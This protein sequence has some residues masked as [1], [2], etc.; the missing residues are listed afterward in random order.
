MVISVQVGFTTPGTITVPIE[1]S[2][3]APG[4]ANVKATLNPSVLVQD[5]A[6]V[7]GLV[8]QE[9]SA[10]KPSTPAENSALSTANNAVGNAKAFANQGDYANSLAQWIN[11]ADQVRTITSVDTSRAKQSIAYA[12]QSSERQLCGQWACVTG[13]LNF[14]VDNVVTRQ[15]A[16]RSTIGTRPANNQRLSAAHKAQAEAKNAIAADKPCWTEPPGEGG[17]L[18]GG[19]HRGL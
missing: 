3:S 5:K 1:F 4:A 15:V 16:L 17:M 13:A 7:D 12:L 2:G 14:T 6:T 11:A 19:V 18:G 10:L 8:N 9:L